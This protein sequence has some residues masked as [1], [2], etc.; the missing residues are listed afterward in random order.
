MKKLPFILLLLIGC[1]Q[2][3]FE[4]PFEPT[5]RIDNAIRDIEFRVSGSYPLSAVYTDDT[6]EPAEAEV[7]WRST[8]EDVITFE[9]HIATVHSEGFTTI[10]ASANGLTASRTVETVGSRGSLLISGF[11]PIIQS[12]NTTPFKFN[13]INADG[14]TDN[15]ISPIWSS[16]NE[17]VATIDMAGNLTAISSGTTDITID[18]DGTGN[19]IEVEVTE[20]EV[21]VD[22][23][24][25]IF[26][27]AQFLEVGDQFQFE[28]DHYDESAQITDNTISWSSSDES[29]LTINSAGLA[30]PISSG[31]AVVEASV[32]GVSATIDV[33]VEGGVVIGRTGMLMGTGYDIEG[34]FVLSE[35]DNGDLILTIENYKPDGPGPYL[36]LANQTSNVANGLNLGAASSAG[37]LTINVSAIDAQVGVNTY[38]YV[39]VW[40]EPFSVRLGYG[41]FEN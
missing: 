30:T 27:F 23:V 9:G 14:Q 7:E 34:D 24:I 3:D 31:D 41:E 13:F 21:M 32:E 16:S 15:S 20:D 2:T 39:I 38:D 28:A 17:S 5:F 1:I 10:V 12:G 4:D 40:C 11:T 8:D 19:V 33:T 26:T 6:G 29:V 36:Y 25:R 18:L 37:N 22:P 35:A